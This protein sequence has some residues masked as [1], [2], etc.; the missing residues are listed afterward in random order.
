MINESRSTPSIIRVIFNEI[1]K[2][3]DSILDSN[4]SNLI[5]I[6]INKNEPVNN[7][8]VSLKSNQKID[9]KFDTINDKYNG[10]INFL[11]CIKSNFENCIISL[12]I[13][14]SPEKSRVYKSLIHE[15]THLYELYQVKDIFYSTSWIKS[16]RLSDFDTSDFNTSDFND[17]SLIRY[18]RDIYYV[19]LPNEVRATISSIEIFLICLIT[20]D[21]NT[22]KSELEK[23]TEWNRYE[24]IRDFNPTEYSSDL[25]ME[26]GSKNTIEII[27]N[28]NKINNINYTIKTISDIIKYFNG[29]KKYLNDVA[30]KM[31]KKIN[32]KIIEISN[33]ENKDEDSYLHE[34]KDIIISYKSYLKENRRENNLHDLTFPN[35]NDYF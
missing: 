27:N 34:D 15:L 23:T 12:S 25:I 11:S 31:N 28:F 8:I 26:Y 16:K 20:K 22:L 29:W 21:P 33:R 17:K 5:S 2:D 35:I 14:N 32:K 4:K 13:P 10:N 1:K 19:S 3:L 30:I 6:N 7:K 18:F 24:S 9:I